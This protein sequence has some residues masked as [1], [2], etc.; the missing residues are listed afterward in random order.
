MS[1]ELLLIPHNH[2]D[3]VWRRCFARNAVR[4]GWT[5]RSYADV[6][7]A[8]F[9]HWLELAG[10]GYSY[11]EGQAA[12]L[13]TYLKR[14]PEAKAAIKAHAASG[15]LNIV[16]AGE[17]VQ[18]SVMPAAEGLIRNFLAAMPLYEELAGAEHPAL[19]LAWVEDAFGHSPNY[20]Q[21]LKGVGAEAA[22][23]I[24]YR[25]VD[26]DLWTGLDGSAIPNFD[27]HPSTTFGS[28]AKHPPCPACK[29]RGC[30]ACAG[31]GMR[32]AP[33]DLAGFAPA[34][35]EALA[36]T[37][38][39]GWSVLRF[40]AEEQLPCPELPALV[41]QWNAEHTDQLVFSNWHEVWNRL[42]P[43]AEKAGAESSRAPVCDLNP[44]MPG[45]LVTRI[46]C[47]QRTRASAYRL[48]AAEAALATAA[49]TAGRPRR[50]PA[51]L[52]KAWRGVCLN[53]FHDAITGTH[54][55]SGYRELMALLD[56]A[57]AIA[58]QR[59]PQPRRQSPPKQKFQPLAGTGEHT[60]RLN[61]YELRFD[62][63]GILEITLD[64]RNV[65]GNPPR[66]LNPLRRESRIAELILQPDFG[67][68][69]GTRIAP[70]F[71]GA[72]PGNGYAD[73]FLGDYHT[74]V[75]TAGDSVRWHGRYRGGDHKVRRLAWTVT[76]SPSADGRR[77]D[78]AT[79]IDWDTG[80]RRIRVWV[81][82][83]SETPEALYEVPFG[84]ISRTYD[85]GKFDYS[86]WQA[87]QCDFGALHWVRKEIDP[88]S[89]VVLFNRGIPCNRWVPGRLELS[90]L[91][92]PEWN[93]SCV[94]PGSY[95]FWDSDGQRDAGRHFFEYAILPYTAPLSHGDV[96]RMGYDYNQPAPLRPPFTVAG[97]VVVTAWKLAQR[98]DAWVLRLQDASGEG[99]AVC[100]DFPSPRQ[101]TP[102]DLLERP[103]AETA[104]A[105]TSWQGQL[106]RHGIQTL[107]IR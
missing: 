38:D 58:N 1:K 86:Q 31:T 98:G 85:A 11:S 65:F 53:Q 19:K 74:R 39:G 80:S 7:A 88:S 2:F 34:V 22:C 79:E 13:R 87:N 71:T 42:K 37:P 35:A 33:F 103:S 10:G 36:K 26:G 21:V 55:D 70:D 12:I 23:F 100:L 106:H 78:F 77:L 52:A 90:L 30:G 93:F 61:G 84:F 46:T 18:D 57:D 76:L 105:A 104:A 6:E 62:L 81:P 95:E 59:L 67:D 83:A 16:L 107:L 63:H 89:G 96:V 50:P 72:G 20:P 43:A 3:P 51:N 64:G 66:Q 27:R 24:S 29:G 4:N 73:I 45:C 25:P 41:R 91:R 68:A 17:T 40:F 56:Q 82:V 14:R 92:S 60:L 48:V 47:K 101:V 5:V 102:C 97:D 54:I 9:D 32:F 49:W 28:F 8:C 94:E 99:T 44:A 75:E 69:W 15:R